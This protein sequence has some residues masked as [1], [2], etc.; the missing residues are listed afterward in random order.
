MIKE[1]D[2][3]IILTNTNF[4]DEYLSTCSHV[5]K[6]TYKNIDR[7]DNNPNVVAIVGSRAMAIKCCD[8]TFPSLKLFQLT[9]AGFDGVPVKKYSE[10]GVVVANA[11]DVYSIPISETVVYGILTIAKKLRKNPN[12]R[13]FKFYRHY[14]QIT[15]L[16]DKRVLIM[17]AGNIGTAVADRLLGFGVKIDAYDPYCSEKPQYETIIRSREDLKIKLNL[18]DYIVCTLP[19]NDQ[20]HNSVN[21]ELFDCMKSTA[22]IVNVGRKAVF[23]ENDFYSALKAKKIGGAVLDMFEKLPN[24]ITN[25]FRRLNNVVVLPGGAYSVWMRKMSVL[26]FV[27]QRLFLTVIPHM[28]NDSAYNFVFS[29][30]YV[31]SLFVCGGT[32]LFSALIIFSSRKIKI[33]KYLF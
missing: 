21:K 11:G 28:L 12:N 29:N 1:K 6:V 2:T 33:F 4:S 18:Y 15:E 20:T 27:T 19:D 14:N 3:Q 16:Y 9:S 8:M 22:V 30:V 10:K 23:N 31:G 24:P 17:G 32:I 25:K 5:E 13:H 26:I 7:F